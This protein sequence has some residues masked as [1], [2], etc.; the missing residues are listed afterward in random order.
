MAL[1]L[2][3]LRTALTLDAD[4]LDNITEIELAKGLTAVDTLSQIL[5]Q[6]IETSHLN[7]DGLITA[8]DM[9]SVNPAAVRAP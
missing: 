8:A 4:L 3:S 9:P 6:V 5:L 7:D 1:S 2:S